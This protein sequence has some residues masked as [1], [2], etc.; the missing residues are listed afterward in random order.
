LLKY[1]EQKKKKGKGLTKGNSPQKKALEKPENR[2]PRNTCTE[3]KGEQPNPGESKSQEDDYELKEG[4]TLTETPYPVTS[5]KQMEKKG[6][7]GKKRNY[8]PR[9]WQVGKK[10][11]N[12]EESSVM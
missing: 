6:E 7:T 4:G 1:R 5:R 9:L 12:Q 2:K 10:V 3:K 11:S 8:R